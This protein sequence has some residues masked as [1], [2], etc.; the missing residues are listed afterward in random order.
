MP[1]RLNEKHIVVTLKNQGIS[2]TDALCD[3]I[4]GKLNVAAVETAAQQG[5]CANSQVDLA[6]RAIWHQVRQFPEF[7]IH[8]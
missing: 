2:P 8:A 7:E 3:S 4:F 1:F 6:S 5:A